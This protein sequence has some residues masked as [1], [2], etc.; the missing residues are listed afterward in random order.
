MLEAAEHDLDAIAPSLAALVVF[1][2]L[3][4]VFATGDAG[5]KALF[6][7]SIAEPVGMI[8]TISE[9]PLAFGKLVQQSGGTDIRS[10][11]PLSLHRFQ[12]L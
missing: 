5:G 1:D 9:Q 7:Q 2:G 8:A 12:R 6:L 3:V 4:P 10:K 11:T